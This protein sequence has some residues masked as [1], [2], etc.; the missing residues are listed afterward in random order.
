M[1]YLIVVLALVCLN[2]SAIDSILKQAAKAEKEAV[3]KANKSKGD[4]VLTFTSGEVVQCV[5]LARVGDEWRYQRK[6]NGKLVSTPVKDATAQ[7]TVLDKTPD[8]EVVVHA[9]YCNGKS[10]EATVKTISIPV[11]PK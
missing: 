8:S 11:W 1:K 7:G 10:C 9:M 6:D 5:W 3:K 4:A 2:A